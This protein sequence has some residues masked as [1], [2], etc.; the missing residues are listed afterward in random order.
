MRNPTAQPFQQV[1]Q[2]RPAASPTAPTRI[3]PTRTRPVLDRALDLSHFSD[4]LSRIVITRQQALNAEERRKTDK[5]ERKADREQEREDFRK[6][7]ELRI[8]EQQLAEQE[9]FRSEALRQEALREENKALGVG[10]LGSR[11]VEP[12]VPADDPA[13]KAVSK[14]VREGTLREQASH[15]NAVHTQAGVGRMK[16]MQLEQVFNTEIMPSYRDYT[17]EEGNIKPFPNVA[18]DMQALED[19]LGITEWLENNPPQ[20][21][22]GYLDNVQKLLPNFMLEASE[23]HLAGQKAFNRA[24]IHREGMAFI[25]G[26]VMQASTSQDADGNIVEGDGID[27]DHIRALENYITQNIFAPDLENPKGAVEDLMFDALASLGRADPQTA[28]DYLEAMEDFKFSLGTGLFSREEGVAGKLAALEDRYQRLEVEENNKEL[29]DAQRAAALTV[30]QAKHEFGESALEAEVNG[31]WAGWKQAV[32][33]AIDADPDKWGNNAF[34]AKDWADKMADG[35]RP[36]IEVSDEGAVD[37]VFKF[38]NAGERL[39]AEYFLQLLED[40]DKITG[41]DAAT[42]RQS[43]RSAFSNADAKAKNTRISIAVAEQRKMVEGFPLGPEAAQEFRT[44]AAGVLREFHAEINAQWDAAEADL[45]ATTSVDQRMSEFADSLAATKFKDLR[46]EAAAAKE[47]KDAVQASITAKHRN[48]APAATEIAQNAGLFSAAERNVMLS[49]EKT[50]T[51]YSDMLS[52]SREFLQERKH[53]YQQ[54]LTSTNPFISNMQDDD[55]GRP[56]QGLGDLANKMDRLFGVNVAARFR[57][58]IP[59]LPDGPT[60]EYRNAVYAEEVDKLILTTKEEVEQTKDSLISVKEKQDAFVANI[61]AAKRWGVNASNQSLEI[62]EV[63]PKVDGLSGDFLEVGRD[64]L[65]GTADR[66]TLRVAGHR[67]ITRIMEDAS[68]GRKEANHAIVR[69]AS[70]SG[71][72]VDEVLSGR[73]TAQA[74]LGEVFDARARAR[75]GSFSPTTGFR[76][77]ANLNFATAQAIRKA[78]ASA[79]EIKFDPA[80]DI[81]PY[82]TPFYASA[83]DLEESLEADPE[84][85]FKFLT[86]LGIDPTNEQEQDEFIYLQKQLLRRIK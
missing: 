49:D 6:A 54:L 37:Q 56:N 64:Y 26:Q 62:M 67:E 65:H 73:F 15:N 23:I 81:N 25:Q 72:T 78:E 30:I 45:A 29:R 47:L 14:N 1:V 74:F 59:G 20:A 39:N 77:S 50:A 66:N 46:E 82:T 32:F 28:L 84:K 52:G 36:L 42:T 68:Y 44:R 61:A 51:D 38:I 8:A 69:V 27:A 24:E 53:L 71:I 40:N 35:F 7:E 58:E 48:R 79:T 60:L 86:A 75:R 13:S 3:A 19:R 17:D 43:I 18:T 11:I 76:P 5:A 41:R 9:G 85:F 80:K 57:S 4:T 63:F 12:G 55:D 34:D 16:A 22:R 70:M 31:D 10:A 21:L 33:E 2:L 83:Q